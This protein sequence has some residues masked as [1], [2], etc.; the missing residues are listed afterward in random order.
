MG[1][2]ES[3]ETEDGSV[4]IDAISLE[5]DSC[6]VIERNEDH[7]V[8][9]LDRQGIPLIE[10]TTAPHIHSPNQAFEAAKYIGDVLRSFDKVKRGLG[11]IRQDLNVS[12]KGGARVEIKGAQNLKLI[13]DMVSDEVRRQRIHL[14]IIDELKSRGVNSHNFSDKKIYDVTGVFDKSRSKVIRENLREEGSKVFA[15]KLFGFKGILKHEM[16]KNYR[17]ATEISDRNKKH[18]P[19]V[20]GLFHLDE[21]PNYGIG[22]REV[23]EVRKLLGIKGKDSFIMIASNDFNLAKRSIR[24][25][26]NIIHELVRGV[27]SEVRWVDPKGTVTNF[28]ETDA[29]CCKDVS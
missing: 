11:T 1:W 26:L 14:S 13:P 19:Q 18:F 17:F 7:T 10:I 12:I 20:K 16:Q 8:F 28:F 3:F 5:E 29:G 22:Q 24:N 9:S 2:A 27:T 23:D 15:V 25:V 21:L 6:R 4:G